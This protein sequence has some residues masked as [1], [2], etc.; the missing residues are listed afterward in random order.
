[1]LFWISAR[2]APGPISQVLPGY[3]VRHPQY[4]KKLF[5]RRTRITKSVHVMYGRKMVCDSMCEGH[6]SSWLRQEQVN[7]LLWHA[8]S[9]LL[10]HAVSCLLW[11]AVSWLSL[12]ILDMFSDK[13]TRVGRGWWMVVDTHVKHSWWVYVASHECVSC[14]ASDECVSYVASD[15]CVSC[16]AS[17]ECLCRHM[18]MLECFFLGSF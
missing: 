12:C 5:V 10:W 18:S 6:W 1:V 15:E 14:V 17:D 7:C 8:V 4:S 11:H 3:R 2:T 16:V 13:C 9:S